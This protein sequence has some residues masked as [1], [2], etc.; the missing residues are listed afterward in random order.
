MDGS[1]Q[2]EGEVGVVLGGLVSVRSEQT[3]SLQVGRWAGRET[4]RIGIQTTQSV[5]LD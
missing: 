2:E 4:D 1:K 5:R 3:S